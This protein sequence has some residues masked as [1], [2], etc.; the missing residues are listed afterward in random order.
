MSI[1][2]GDKK[3]SLRVGGKDLTLNEDSRSYLPMRNPEDI[4]SNLIVE[5]S[6]P[7]YSPIGN[8]IV[9]YN[10]IDGGPSMMRFM[11]HKCEGVSV[12]IDVPTTDRILPISGMYYHN[13]MINSESPPSI[14]L[15]SHRDDGIY[16]GHTRVT[17]INGNW[18]L[19]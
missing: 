9:M 18:I 1:A 10:H 8:S 17:D 13:E 14:W 11:N 6:N 15:I 3:I 7:F 4:P 12:G 16:I 2:T 5:Y 19:K